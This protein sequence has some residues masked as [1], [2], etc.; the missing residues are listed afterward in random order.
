MV[1]AASGEMQR[2][3]IGVNGSNQNNKNGGKDKNNF[4]EN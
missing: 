1:L 3:S 2:N 4:G